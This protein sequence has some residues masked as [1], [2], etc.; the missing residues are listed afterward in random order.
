VSNSISQAA[1]DFMGAFF[2]AGMKASVTSHKPHVILA[3]H[4]ASYEECKE[5]GLLTEEPW[6][7]FGS[8]KIRP[9]IKG[10]EVAQEAC[11]ARAKEIF[12]APTHPALNAEPGHDR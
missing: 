4:R 10:A 12:D 6:N 9:T 2:W 7:D 3:R 1:R 11:R 5:A 8:V